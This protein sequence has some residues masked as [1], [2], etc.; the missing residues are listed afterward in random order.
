[1]EIDGT[2][3]LADVVRL[4]MLCAWTWLSFW[5]GRKYEI[6]QREIWEGR[7]RNGE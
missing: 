5:V 1:M 7:N 4:V 6:I 2:L 3:G